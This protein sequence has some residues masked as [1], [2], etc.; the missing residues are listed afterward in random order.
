MKLRI[1]RLLALALLLGVAA[2]AWAQLS[3]AIY[4]SDEFGTLVN[5]NVYPSKDDVFLNGGPP[6]KAP[7]TSGGLPD[8][9]YYFQV[10]D[11]SGATLLSS[12]EIEERRVRVSGGVFMTYLGTT[13]AVG[14]GKC[15]SINGAI[16]VGL[17]PY[18]DTPNPGGEYKVWI[19]PVGAYDPPNGSHGFIPSNTKT[20]NFKVRRRECTDDCDGEPEPVAIVGNKFYD[21]DTDG[22]WDNTEPPI[23]GWRIEKFPPEPSDVTYTATS[24]Q[25]SF[26]VD[27][28]SGEYTISEVPPLPGWFP[29]GEW[30]NTT[31]TSGNVT[32][33]DEDV[34]GP[35]FGNVCLGAGGGR[36]LGFWSNKNGERIFTSHLASNLALLQ[37][38]CLRNANGSNFDPAN[39]GQFRTWLLRATATNM[40]YML[41][42]QLAAMELNVANG[43]V[44]GSSLAYAPDTNSAN[45]AGFATISDLMTEANAALCTYGLVLDGHPQRS[46]LEALK[47]ALDDGNNNLNFVQSGPEAC[48]F[49]TPY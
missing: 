2:P 46:Y 1:G 28:D 7:C 37:G 30:I 14:Q 19:T 4:T 24:G 41:S 49:D 47:D 13:H 31:P 43:L 32:V 22:I 5:G 12:D 21:T 11:P 20:D 38:L 15:F 34:A 9:E 16:S 27:P 29:D 45:G 40:A 18:D 6:P 10:T 48:P 3:G 17:M 25:Y 39:Y 42:A 35:D 36:T 44:S 23:P 33:E 26:L 8:G